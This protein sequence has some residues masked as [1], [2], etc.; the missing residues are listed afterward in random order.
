MNNY[1]GRAYIFTLITVLIWAVAGPTIKYTLRGFDPEVFLAYR[2]TISAAVVVF[3]MIT[4]GKIKLP[5]NPRILLW[6]LLYAFLSSTVSLGL[7]FIGI[8]KTNAVDA[9]LIGAAGPL[10]T[11]M[12]GMLFLHEHITKR[13]KVGIAVAFVGT[14]ITIIEPTLRN[15]NGS[16]GLTGNILVFSAVILGVLTAVMAKVLM[17]EKLSPISATNLTFLVGFITMIPIVL[18]LKPLDTIVSEISKVPF[19]YHL[20][21]F[22][23]A[24][25]SGNIAYYLW[26]RAEKSIEIGEVGIFSYLSPI[27]A[28]PLAVIWLKESITFPFII[29]AL[30]IASGVIIAEYKK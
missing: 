13:E 23:M 15:H 20:G 5:K 10:F 11:T 29:G 21:V 19:K 6:S 24:I 16:T 18:Y 17:R 28:A 30:V 14:I 25:A 22:Y 1:R 4:T 27:I 7:L 3:F 26:H 12:A 9:I 8:D 2:F